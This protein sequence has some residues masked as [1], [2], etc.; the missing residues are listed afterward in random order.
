MNIVKQHILELLEKGCREDGRKFEEYRKIKVEKGVIPRTAEG[1][2]RVKIGNTEVIA[3]VK[4]DIGKPYPDTEDQGSIMVNMELLPLA[5]PEFE[6]GPPSIG[7][8]ELSRVT[9]RAIRESK[10]LNLKKLCI[11]KA[12][13]S[14][15]V[16]IDIY[17]I[18]DD[19]N[20]FDACA[21]AAIAALKEAKI[22]AYKNG[23][24][25]YKIKKDK[26]PL[27]GTPLSCTV[28]KNWKNFY[29]R[30]NS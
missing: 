9:D 15:N 29:N 16:F 19:G 24:I 28:R 30:S 13:E 6:S 1:S 14:W 10:A 5:S 22:P 2:A 8:I 27:D 23:K 18:N 3:G 20:L 25:D 26:L 7:S 11:K 4:M 17:P 21:L 12:E